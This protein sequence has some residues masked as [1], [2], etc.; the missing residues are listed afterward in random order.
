MVNIVRK[1]TY[2]DIYYLNYQGDTSQHQFHKLVA[3]ESCHFK[4]VMDFYVMLHMISILIHF[5]LVL[6]SYTHPPV[7]SLGKTIGEDWKKASSGSSHFTSKNRVKGLLL[8][9][10]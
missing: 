7:N 5:S 9:P 8:K 2:Q 4:W 1:F 10:T 3:R 6:K